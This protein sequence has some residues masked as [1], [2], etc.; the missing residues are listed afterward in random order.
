MAALTGLRNQSSA[1]LLGDILTRSANRGPESRS[2][3][4]VVTHTHRLNG[5]YTHGGGYPHP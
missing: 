3:T 4:V 1:A 5:L 2:S